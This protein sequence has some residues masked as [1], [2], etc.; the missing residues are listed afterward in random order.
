MRSTLPFAVLSL[1]LM[2]SPTH[3]AEPASQSALRVSEIG[4]GRTVVDRELV[5][6]AEAFPA[7]V[8]EVVCRT[9]VEGAEVPTHVTHVWLLAGEEQRRIELAPAAR[10]RLLAESDEIVAGE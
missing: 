3:A 6:Q 2:G 5:G 1:I 4:V 9:R 10:H 7:D 8:G